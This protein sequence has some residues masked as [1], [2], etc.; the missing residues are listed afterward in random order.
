MVAVR[1]W[2][3]YRGQTRR[4]LNQR[5]KGTD[6]YGW[7]AWESRW[8]KSL[9]QLLEENLYLPD[10]AA[11]GIGFPAYAATMPMLTSDERPLPWDFAHHAAY[12]L[13]LSSEFMR[14]RQQKARGIP[15]SDRLP[16]G[17]SPA[18]SVARR[19]EMYDTYLC[20][21]PHEEYKV[22]HSQLIIN[23]L[24]EA[25]TQ[26]RRK[27][28][29]KMADRI[30]LMISKEF[31]QQNKHIDAIHILKSIWKRSLWRE[32]AWW[33]LHTELTRTLHQCALIVGD[34]ESALMT[35]WELLSKGNRGDALI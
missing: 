2:R 23:L 9:A 19:S 25:G 34:F 32:A 16:P 15:E 30:D 29:I 5:G 3:M 10:P 6:S 11:G 31:M 14:M 12:W 24:S 28:Q 35:H 21:E 4:L 8:S 18:T 26:F 33:P 7:L 17:Q 13:V 27:D 22:H 20:P 1:R